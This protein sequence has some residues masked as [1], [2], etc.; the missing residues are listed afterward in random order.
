[1]TTK[2]LCAATEALALNPFDS[3][4]QL[5]LAQL[6]HQKQ[7]VDSH[8]DKGAQIKARL[9]WLKVGDRASEEFFRALRAHHTSVGIKKIKE[10]QALLAELP[11]ILQAFVHHYEKVFTA[12]GYSSAKTQALQDYL[13]VV[14][15]RLSDSQ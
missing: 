9:H 15:K 10:G 13:L 4:L 5:R 11:E 1:M 7:V 3:T 2:S 14:P 8:S 6:C 12:K